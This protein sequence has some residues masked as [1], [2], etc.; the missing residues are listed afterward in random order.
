MQPYDVAIVGGGAAGLSTALALGRACRTVILFDD[1]QPRN[2]VTKHM[3]GF[4]SRE[5][6]S[7]R[8]FLSIARSQLYRYT[9]VHFGN[10]RI[11]SIDVEQ[12]GF[13]L[14]PIRGAPVLCN[15][16]V[17][18][19]GIRDTLPAITNIERFWGKSV[20]V[21]PFCDGWEVRG[22]AIVVYGNASQAVEL[23]QELIAWT[24]DLL[25]CSPDT[26]GISEKQRRWLRAAHVGL[27]EQSIDRLLGGHESM[28]AIMLKNTEIVRCRALF[29]TVPERQSC[30]LSS[31]LG[32][33]MLKDGSLLIDEW[34]RTTV[35]GCYAAG[36]AAASLHQVIAAAASGTRCAVAIVRDFTDELAARLTK[37][38][39]VLAS[40]TSRAVDVS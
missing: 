5:G 16:V 26:R 15:R 40:E 20:F 11:Q 30:G 17:L 35:A 33:A 23:A 25:I 39:S 27:R 3:H 36:D 21:C 2:N 34:G 31:K 28:R 10:V 22:Q 12:T 38:S 18:A 1:G 8:K 14:T 32:C 9:N 13:T 19:N 37:S 6:I 24:N 29:L 7:P 4:V